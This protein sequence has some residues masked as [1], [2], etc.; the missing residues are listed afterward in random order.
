MPDRE[1]QKSMARVVRN[2]LVSNSHDVPN[3]N[4]FYRL[5]HT[6]AELALGL[7]Q[8]LVD[9]GSKGSE[10]FELLKIAWD[11]TRLRN[12]NY[13]TA[14][15]NNDM[16]Y[17]GFLLN[18]IFLALQFHVESSSRTAPEAVSKKPE[19]STDLSV[20]LE[21]IK[22][23]VAQGFRSLTICLHEEPQKCSPKDFAV[24]TA[25]LQTALRVRDV[26]RIYEEISY[27]LT[28]MDSPRYATTLF[29]WSYKLTV[30]GDPI[31]GE[32]SILFLLEMSCIPTMA[33]QMAADGVLMKL[34]TYRLMDILRQTQGCGPFDQVPRLYS[35]WHAGILPMCL[36]L[37]YYVG[38]A[39]PEVAAFLNQFQGQLRR[40]S[41]AFSI[42]HPPA[43]GLVSPVKNSIL[44]GNVKGI[45]LGMASEACSLA[46]LSV[47]FQKFREAGPS[48]G[49][50]S[51]SI[52]ELQWDS[53]QV[54]DDIEALLEKRTVLRARILP[55]NDK[56]LAL[57]RRAPTPNPSSTDP[58]TLLEEKIVKEFQK[59]LMCINGGD[60]G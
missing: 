50:D 51:Q 42:S 39:A 52:Q 60:G 23:V 9:I 54:K 11:A 41:D 44:R 56:E 34:S 46:L 48:T 49:V 47:I 31:Y 12:P 36:N 10:V 38:R 37:V 27:H 32:L 14:L 58:H 2:C 26:D 57:S 3:E 18:L 13:E 21:I 40:A 7:L 1:V 45:T 59:T 55:T 24:L 8:R 22:N 20:V 25:I 19:V 43:S 5:Q 33:E 4:I 17:Y 53:A 15:I 35:I 16:E 29:S 30:E 28:D 6:R